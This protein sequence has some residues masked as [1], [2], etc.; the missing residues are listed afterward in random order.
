[1]RQSTQSA[2]RVTKGSAVSGPVDQM[3][4]SHRKP[5]QFEHDK[6]RSSGWPLPSTLTVSQRGPVTLLRLSRPDKRNALDLATIAGLETFFSDPPEE[7]RV[8]VL[9]GEGKH[10]SAG[11]DLGSFA[12]TSDWDRVLLCETWHRAFDR[13]E[14][15]GL[16]VIAA[17][18]GGV[19]GGGLELAASAHI[20][21]AERNSYYAL[22][23]GARGIF[24]GGGG[25]V[26][27]PRLI[28]ASRMV[29]MMLT[30]RIYGA[31]EGVSLGFSQYL[32][33]DGFALAKAIELAE[34]IATNTTLSNFAIAQA[35]LRIARS[36]PDGGF[37]MESLMAAVA[38]GD[39]EAAARINAFFEKRAPKVAPLA[40]EGQP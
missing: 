34:Q 1:M 4:R 24:V 31:E 21:V 40:G 26:R 6:Q 32:F 3:D 19:I 13:I 22:P 5:P 16:P 7:T 17:L 18:H 37:L 38:I 28:G 9:F 8:I 20:R 15:G 12:D 27:V 25:A 35:L 10:F 2:N 14:N 39:E 33:N 11:A 29:D 30:G 36:S 23:E